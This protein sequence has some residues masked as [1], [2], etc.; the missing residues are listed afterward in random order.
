MNIVQSCIHD[1]VDFS[2]IQYSGWNWD[3]ARDPVGKP[4]IVKWNV[5]LRNVAG[6]CMCVC[7]CVCEGERE[8]ERERE[9]ESHLSAIKQC[10]WH[11][12]PQGFT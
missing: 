3:I 10:L 11:W 9:R 8:R 6:V 1:L 5:E 4:A 7:V 2:L 12:S